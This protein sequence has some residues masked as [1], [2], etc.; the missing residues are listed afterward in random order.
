MSSGSVTLFAALNLGRVLG[1]TMTRN[2]DPDHDLHRRLSVDVTEAQLQVR[3][4]Q[5]QVKRAAD[6]L[7]E[8]RLSMAAA[9]E[10]L[11]EARR[12][13]DRIVSLPRTRVEPG[14]R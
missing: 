13:R 7:T 9:M 8:A 12:L 6:R 10:R 1:S 5:D 14:D 4:C 11:T 3:A 2:P